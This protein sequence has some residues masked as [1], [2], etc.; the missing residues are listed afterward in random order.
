MRC[1]GVSGFGDRFGTIETRVLITLVDGS[2]IV[3]RIRM[4]YSDRTIPNAGT[5][6]LTLEG[7]TD[8][9]SYAAAETNRQLHVDGSRH[10]GWAQDARFL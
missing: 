2:P 5:F 9:L 4:E 6:T 3:A 10:G 7:S 8:F 1:T